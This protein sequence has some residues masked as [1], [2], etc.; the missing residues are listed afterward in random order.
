VLLICPVIQIFAQQKDYT[1]DVKSTENIIAELYDVIS[2]DAGSSRDWDRFKNLFSVDG[3]LIPTF[4]DKEGKTGYRVMAP[5]DYAQMFTT[6]VTTGFYERELHHVTESFGTIV[7]V[8][9]TYE[10]LDKKDGA[11]TNRGINSIQLLKSSDRYYIMNVFW[12]AETSETQL[13]DKYLK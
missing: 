10:T 8:F 3:K 11:V 12:S 13:P 6:R 7:H 9:S 2:G 5:S 4:K 1:Q